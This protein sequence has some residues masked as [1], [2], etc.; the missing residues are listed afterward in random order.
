[1]TPKDREDGKFI[2]MLA[3]IIAQDAI[4]RI[5]ADEK[6]LVEMAEDIVSGL[7][8]DDEDCES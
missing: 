1:M 3:E 4:D 2:V 8:T 5:V 7:V 6:A